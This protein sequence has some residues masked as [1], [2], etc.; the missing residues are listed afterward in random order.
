MSVEHDPRVLGAGLAPTPFTPEQI[1]AGCPAGRMIRLLVEEEGVEPYFRFHHFTSCDEAGAVIERGRVDRGRE[2]VVDR[3]S[4][5]E[6]QEH[7][8]FPADVTTI[9][10]DTIDIPLGVVECLRYTVRDDEGVT[11][12]WFSAAYPGMPVR[13]SRAENGRTVSTTTMI[14]SS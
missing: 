10:E 9:E 5:R 6:L 14:A 7:A 13:Y 8:A 12:F 2:V 1:R 4:W 3:S 11:T